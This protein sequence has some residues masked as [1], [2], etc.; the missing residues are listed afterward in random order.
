MGL[1]GSV[2]ALCCDCRSYISE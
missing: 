1:I 2:V